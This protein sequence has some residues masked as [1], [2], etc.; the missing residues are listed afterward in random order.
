M[1]PNDGKRPIYI[2]VEGNLGLPENSTVYDFYGA[3][4]FNK[5]HSILID[6]F[7]VNRSSSLIDAQ[8][9]FG[10]VIAIKAKVDIYD[11]SKFYNLSYGY[12]MYKKDNGAITLVAGLNVINMNYSI[13]LNGNLT[14]K[15][16]DTI[17]SKQSILPANFYAPL[18]LVGLNFRFNYTPRFSVATKI[19][20]VGGT[21]NEISAGI[22][23]SSL[24]ALYAVSDHVGLILGLTY[25]DAIINID[26]DAVNTKITYGYKGVS[27]GVH[28]AF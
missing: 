11:K 18:P 28:F 2:D 23:Q 22:L 14:N 8:K 9:D 20:L 16:G 24:G 25:F 3:Y 27:A 7:F 5:K 13:E 1:S 15:E 6:Y 10:D 4:R 12:N 19:A 26:N 21:Y 17:A